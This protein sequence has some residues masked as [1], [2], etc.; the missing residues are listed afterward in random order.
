MACCAF[1]ELAYKTERLM[2]VEGLRVDGRKHDEIRLRQN[3]RILGG[4]IDGV[5]KHR[6]LENVLAIDADDE[7]ARPDLARRKCNRPADQ[8]EADDTDTMEDRRPGGIFLALHHRQPLSR[9]RNLS[10]TPTVP[11]PA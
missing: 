11:S 8:P 5:E 6:T 9:T 3:H 2:I 10:P 1:S 4:H 7:R